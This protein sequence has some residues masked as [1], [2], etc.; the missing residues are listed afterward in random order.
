VTKDDLLDDTAVP[1][2]FAVYQRFN[3]REDM[4]YVT[5]SLRELGITVRTSDEVKSGWREAVIIGHSIEP[6]FWI[7]IPANRFEQANFALQEVAEAELSEEDLLT[8]PFADYNTEELQQVLLEET[9][10]SP[11]AVVIARRL[12]L[13]SGGDVDL[14][15]IRQ[16]S[17]ERLAAAF[18]PQRGSVISLLLTS[19]IG[20]LAGF[21]VWFVGIMITLGILLYYR[22]GTRMDPKGVRHW[23][24]VEDTRKWAFFGL[25]IIGG[26]TLF[27]LANLFFLHWYY[28]A[29]VDA[30]LWWWR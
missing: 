4:D 2:N 25:L 26:S 15:A 19:L 20:A 30:W 5:E 27:G 1:G 29:D 10:W 14:A 17:R 28:F 22:I 13:R 9:E 6:K 7:E 8:H 24:Y 23:A 16:A 18:Q 11:D 3:R 21:I 12:L